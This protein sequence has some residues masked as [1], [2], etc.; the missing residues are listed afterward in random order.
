MANRRRALSDIVTAIAE[1][2]GIARDAVNRISVVRATAIEIHRQRLN[3]MVSVGGD[4][5]NRRSIGQTQ[6]RAAQGVAAWTGTVGD[7]LVGTARAR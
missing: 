5:R 2:E 7:C 3:T 1:V 6:R 4:Y